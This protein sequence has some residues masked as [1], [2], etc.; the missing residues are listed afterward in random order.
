MHKTLA[1]L[2]L[3]LCATLTAQNITVTGTVF[4]ADSNELLPGASV[5]VSESNVG[6]TT[7]FDGNFTLE[8]LKVEDQIIISYIG[9]KDYT[10]TINSSERLSIGLQISSS[11]LDEIVVIGYGTQTKKEVT[12]A[13]S[14]VGSE[15]IGK[16]NPSRVEQAL[17]GQ[18]SGVNITSNSGSPGSG[19]KIN[20]RGV[21]TNG[22]N[23]PLILVDGNVIEDLSVLNP[24]DIKSVNVIKDATAGIYGVRGAN[25][26]ILIELKK[27]TKGSPLSLEVDT[28][29]GLQSASRTMDLMETEDYVLYTNEYKKNKFREMPEYN[30]DWQNEVLSNAPILS[31]NISAN[32]GFEKSSYSASISY[33]NQDGIVGLDKSNYTRLTTRLSYNY[34]LLKNL[35][36]NFSGIY[37]N[38][39]KNN[40]SENGIGSILYS[41]INMSPAIPVY[42][43]DDFDEITNPMAFS[44]VNL[45]SAIEIANPMALIHNS[46]NTTNVDKFSGSLGLSYDLSKNIELNSSF[47]FNHSSVLDDVFRPVAYYGTAKSSNRTKFEIQDYGAN[48]DD[49]TW[50]N[51]LKYTNDFNELNIKLLVGTSIFKTTGNFYGYTF[52]EGA[53]SNTPRFTADAI[54]KG[55]DVFDSRLASIFSRLQINYKNRILF[56]SVIRRDGSSKFSPENKFGIFPSGSIGW[57]ISE[58]DFFN[59]SPISNLKIRASYG[60]IG[61]DRI[62]DFG[63]VS[64][65]NGE[66]VYSNNVEESED[67]LLRGVAIGSLPNPEIRWEKQNTS[68]FGID[69]SFLNNNLNLSLEKYNRETE[70]LLIA[71]QTSG[72][73]GG[74]APGSGSPY[75]NAGTVQNKGY[76][77]S[78]SFYHSLSDDINFNIGYNISTI[79]NEVLFVESENGFQQGGSWGVGI[80]VIPSRMQAGYPLGYFYGFKTEGL[81]QTQEEI[82]ILDDNAFDKDG[83][84]VDYHKGAKVGDLK[85]VDTNEDGVITA[86]DKTYIGDPIPDLTMGMSFGF[87]FKDFDF[88]AYAH[89]SIGNEMIRD[90]ERQVTAANRGTYML[91]R[92]NAETGGNTIPRASSGSSINNSDLSDYFV[93]DASY[94][95]IQNVQL[96][97]TA[98][99]NITDIL[100]LT[101]LRMY[102]SASN[103]FTFTKYNGFDPSASGTSPIGAGIDKGFYP[104]SR[105]IS[106]GLNIKI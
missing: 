90:Y 22:D 77:A 61:N 20:I 106:F 17:Q 66:A 19:L 68:N 78:L 99:E 101:S 30:V 96:G 81:Y 8:N 87:R 11:K 75:I 59:F 45:I 57:N 25:G 50:D 37:T 21:S 63:F 16:L 103:L 38:S 55:D 26:V 39:I 64:R 91:D 70:D 36:L 98:N 27:G 88:N 69:I 23:R 32:G 18:V 86:E 6:T 102:L 5:V 94:I 92:W 97:Y 40:L 31:T 60:I 85:F 82:D 14:V 33:L 47:Q 74:A 43:Q 53:A 84:S 58:E 89:A 10:V 72:L 35:R 104:V 67:D 65:L 52:E 13:V 34:D 48:F 15:T 80:G 83:E 62:R 29:F 42:N 28:F 49:Y 100:N 71:A 73:L 54:S 12:G 105:V 56:S 1:I 44:Y 24:K 2:S 79:D 7:D 9:Y 51:F 3:L 46:Q 76:E 4:D 95:R 41:A 93:E